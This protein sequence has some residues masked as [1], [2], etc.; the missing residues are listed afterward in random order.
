M[1]AP[2]LEVPKAGLDGQPEL[3]GAALPTGQTLCWMGFKV[4]CNLSHSVID[5]T[6][7]GFHD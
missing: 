4:P 3:V 5:S 6:I 2:S 7:D 1:G